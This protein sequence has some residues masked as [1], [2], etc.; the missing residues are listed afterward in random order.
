MLQVNPDG[1][2][3]N[4]SFGGNFRMNVSLAFTNFAKL[5]FSGG[6]SSRGDA[7]EPRDSVDVILSVQAVLHHTAS[8]LLSNVFT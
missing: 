2:G 7:R 5:D 4:G 3:A 1:M 8:S 6:A